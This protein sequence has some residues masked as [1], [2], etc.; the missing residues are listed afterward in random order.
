MQPRRQTSCGEAQ[1]HWRLCCTGGR[2]GAGKTGTSPSIFQ[3]NMIHFDR[4]T[5]IMSL[6]LLHF[7]LLYPKTFQ[8]IMQ[9]KERMKEEPSSHM[10]IPN[11]RLCMPLE[12]TQFSHVNDLS[13]KLLRVG[14]K[15]EGWWQRESHLKASH[16]H[17][18]LLKS[19]QKPF[20]KSTKNT[21]AGSWSKI[22]VLGTGCIRG[23]PVLRGPITD[24]LTQGL[25][26]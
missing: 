26:E 23:A 15:R 1:R 18:L 10:H 14:C 21:S 2:V 5:Y 24:G 7:L 6:I 3:A 19:E 8:T 12:Y 4:I 25:F 22:K 16:A 13:I 11:I 17:F 20:W 9:H